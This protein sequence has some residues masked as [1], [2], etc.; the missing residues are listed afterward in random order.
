MARELDLVEQAV[1]NWVRQERIDRSTSAGLRIC[2]GAP[3]LV[4]RLTSR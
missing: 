1:S 4:Y 2:G 3:S